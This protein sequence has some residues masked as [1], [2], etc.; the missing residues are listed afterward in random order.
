MTSG[1]R[2]A[3]LQANALLGA[4]EGFLV[5]KSRTKG[6]TAKN[7]SPR[8]ASNSHPGRFFTKENG[9]LLEKSSDKPKKERVDCEG[10]LSKVPSVSV[11]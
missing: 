10:R 3:A 2:A 7:F 5:T 6:G 8:M 11:G 1:G 4:K 9:P